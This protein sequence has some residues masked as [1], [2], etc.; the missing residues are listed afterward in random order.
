MEKI[1]NNAE[2]SYHKVQRAAAIA[3]GTAGYLGHLGSKEID[4]RMTIYQAIMDQEI[5]GHRDNNPEQSWVK[6]LVNNLGREGVK[7]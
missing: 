5:T 2:M 6:L 1:L 7:L 4:R 3:A